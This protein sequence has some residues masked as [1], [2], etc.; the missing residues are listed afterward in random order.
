MVPIAI[1][2][3]MPAPQESDDF[4]VGALVT[5]CT[6]VVSVAVDE[7]VVDVVFA[8]KSRGIVMASG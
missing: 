6:I 3:P 2:I 1:P 4:D 5:I 8:A 7:F